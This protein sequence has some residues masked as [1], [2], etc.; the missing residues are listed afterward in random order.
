MRKFLSISLLASALAISAC[1][2]VT[3]EQRLEYSKT[4]N[5]LNN[6][7]IS[8]LS[9]AC[10]TKVEI[11]KDPV[12]FQQ[13]EETAKQTSDILKNA[14]TAKNLS[15]NKQL[16]PLVCGRLGDK[17][18]KK[19]SIRYTAKGK[20]ED[21]KSIPILSTGNTN[22][23]ELNLAYAKLFKA[24]TKVSQSSPSIKT[25]IEL[26]DSDAKLLANEFASDKTFVILSSATKASFAA[27]MAIAAPTAL[28]TGGAYVSTIPQGQFYSIY[29]LDIKNKQ[30]EWIKHPTP[31]KG[32]VLKTPVSIAPIPNILSPLYESK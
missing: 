14:L 27:N 31:L 16:S 20:R 8:V 22:S 7:T 23:K 6:S 19:M 24:L 21:I 3:P 18:L 2:T 28:L 32:R 25:S 5:A 9:T 13:A 1:S 26:S 11:G 29:L 4:Q 30:V 10:V 15:V 17:A 12:L